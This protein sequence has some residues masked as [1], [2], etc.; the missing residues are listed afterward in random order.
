VQMITTTMQENVMA[1]LDAH[2]GVQR[3]TGLR[4]ARRSNYS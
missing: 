1:R 3:G 2:M 4:G